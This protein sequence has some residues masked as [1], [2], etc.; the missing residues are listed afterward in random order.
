[1]KINI[2]LLFSYLTHIFARLIYLFI[3]NIYLSYKIRKSVK[4]NDVENLTIRDASRLR[5][6]LGNIAIESESIVFMVNTTCCKYSPPYVYCGE[7]G[8]WNN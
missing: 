8:V 4:F 1:M 3:I 2:T 5:K 7:T 6:S